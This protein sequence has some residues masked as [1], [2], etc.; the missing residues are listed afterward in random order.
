MMTV[1]FP[2][3]T[4]LA[5]S[6]A[7]SVLC[8]SPAYAF[9]A[10]DVAGR[11]AGTLANSG[12]S[13]SWA[14]S[15]VNG[16]AIV[17]EGVKAGLAG[18]GD[19]VEVGAVVL[20][21]VAEADD[22]TYTV[23]LVSLPDYSL[24]EDGIK[25]S[26]SGATLSGLV[27]P[28]EGAEKSMRS[29]VPYTGIALALINVTGP[30]GEIFNMANLNAVMN[31]PEDGGQADFTTTIEGFTINSASFP[32]AEARAVFAA[33]GYSVV[34]GS[35]DSHGTWNTDDGQMAI[36][37]MALSVKD[38][39]TLDFNL[40]IGGYTLEFLESMQTMQ[41]KMMEEGED[42]NTGL[43]MLGLMQQITFHSAKVR[44][45]DQSLTNKVLQFVADQQGMKPSDIANQAKAILPFAMAQL[46]NPDFTAQVTAAVSAYLDNPQSIEVSADP[47][48]PLPI[49][50]LIAGGMSAPEQLP[51][52][53]GVKVTA[54]E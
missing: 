31:I 52:Q 33:L 32:E 42:E 9:E 53:L 8:F 49:A 34:E 48:E 15:S 12:Y 37:K 39:G 27:L 46:N 7:F 24:E 23:E 4:L 28:P 10:E 43:A 17:L 19:E 16:D 50:M 26:M 20:N 11:L 14:S 25:V 1:C 51:N 6:T 13:I 41:K 40:D 3:K 2:T 35:M 44:F 54:N 5:A 22:G 18:A 29:I 38:A 36:N 45:D 47:G 30:D 21:G